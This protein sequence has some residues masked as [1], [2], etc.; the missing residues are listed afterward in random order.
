MTDLCWVFPFVIVHHDVDVVEAVDG[1]SETTMSSSSLQL[2]GR[3]VVPYVPGSVP[4]RRP[5]PMSMM[6][7]MVLL[8]VVYRRWKVQFLAVLPVDHG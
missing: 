4:P 7:W 8:V 1:N 2:Q 6:L 3:M 5:A